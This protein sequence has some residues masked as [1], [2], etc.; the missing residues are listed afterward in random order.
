V[1]CTCSCAVN[2]PHNR[3]CGAASMF[4]FIRRSATV[5]RMS[6]TFDLSCQENAT[7]DGN[8]MG[9]WIPRGQV[10]GPE[11]AKKPDEPAKKK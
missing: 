3:R 5:V 11:L 6:P 9:A 8:G 7:H 1:H 2:L 10:R 4:K